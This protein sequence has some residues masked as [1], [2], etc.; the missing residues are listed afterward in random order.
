MVMDNNT[1]IGL[2]YFLNRVFIYGKYK[3][4]YE[5]KNP[6][7]L[8]WGRSDNTIIGGVIYNYFFICKTSEYGRCSFNIPS[9]VN[10]SDFFILSSA[11]RGWRF[12]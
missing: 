10:S 12:V 5:I 9:G 11:Q 3:K 2:R 4:K 8:E 6:T 7:L 1:T